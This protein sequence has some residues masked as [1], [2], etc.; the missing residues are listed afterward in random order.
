MTVGEYILDLIEDWYQ[1][2]L[3]FAALWLGEDEPDL[4]LGW[5][6]D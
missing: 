3:R 1:A 5:P 6:T 2:E 4:N